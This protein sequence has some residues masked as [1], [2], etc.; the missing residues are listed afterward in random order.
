MLSHQLR[1]ETGHHVSVT[2]C[3]RDEPSTPKRWSSESPIA[4]PIRD[5]YSPPGIHRQKVCSARMSSVGTVVREIE[6][7]V[8]VRAARLRHSKLLTRL[9]YC[10]L[11]LWP[12]PS[13][14]YPSDL[15]S[16]LSLLHE[17]GCRAKWDPWVHCSM[18]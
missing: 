6:T 4:G 14:F 16:R 9:P 3:T 18:H 11:S 5:L 12:Y 1:A 10:P 13:P 8:N 2:I 15:L 7:F 17:T